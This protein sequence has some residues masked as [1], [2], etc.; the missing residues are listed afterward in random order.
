VTIKKGSDYGVNTPLPEDAPVASSDAELRDFVL[1]LR[2]INSPQL[3]V[4]LVGGDLC[5]TLGGSGDVNRLFTTD[6]LKVPVDLV[7]ALIDGVD[8]PFVAHLIVG[9][10][11]CPGFVAMMNAQWLGPLDLG[12]RSHP[13]D[14]LVDITS[15]SL[16]W[17]ERRIARS[18]ARTGTHLPHPS[19]SHKRTNVETLLFERPAPICIDGALEVQGRSISVRVEPDAFHVVV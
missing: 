4:G 18:R 5:K 8:Y 12:P 7:I 17:R 15:G 11:F 13:G 16:K 10:P 14:G 3:T 6:A 19:L 2:T 1:S 9:K